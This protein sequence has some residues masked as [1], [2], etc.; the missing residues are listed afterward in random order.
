M[1]IRDIS[2]GQYKY[3][4]KVVAFNTAGRWSR[5]VTEEIARE[6]LDNAVRS[7]EPL[8]QSA[9]SFIERVTDKDIPLDAIEGH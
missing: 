8:T 4:L 9:R 5:D 7:G 1:V 6:L 2:Q 3:A